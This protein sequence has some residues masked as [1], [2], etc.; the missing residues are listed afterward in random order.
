MA[1]RR[2]ADN[3]IISLVCGGLAEPDWVFPRGGVCKPRHANALGAVRSRLP[4]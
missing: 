2:G 3:P 4:S 1:A